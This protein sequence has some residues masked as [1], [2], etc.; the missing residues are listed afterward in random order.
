MET[1]IVVLKKERL[2]YHC[3][4]FYKGTNFSNLTQFLPNTQYFAV[5]GIE[6]IKR[7]HLV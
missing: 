3:I 4:N 7:K 1:Q 2:L 5:T 6:S